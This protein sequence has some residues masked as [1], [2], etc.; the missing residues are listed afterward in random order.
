MLIWELPLQLRLAYCLAR[1]PR[2]PAPL[3]ASLVG[4]LAIILNP[5]I[6]LPAW[7]PVIGQMDA[8]A[9]TVLT[10]RTFNSQAPRELREEI[11]AQIR[12]GQSRFDLDLKMGAQG[13][14]RLTNLARLLPGGRSPRRLSQAPTERPSE[15]AAWYRSPALA[16]RPTDGAGGEAGPVGP[17]PTATEEPPI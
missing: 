10:V 4:A 1:D 7:I 3:K 17:A 6:D 5:A 8:I 9:L 13:A 2:T 11:E 15:V 14:R 12:A 16:E